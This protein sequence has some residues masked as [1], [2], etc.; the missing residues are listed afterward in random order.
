MHFSEL[1]ISFKKACLLFA[2][3]QLAQ[4]SF[5]QK[6]DSTQVASHFS[7]AVSVTHNGIS[8]IPSFSLG[9]PAAIFDMAVG[10]RRLSFE[11]QFRFALAGKPWSFLFW[12]RYKLFKNSKL[13]ISIGAHPALNFKTESFSTGGATRE[14]IIS[15]RYLAGELAPNY[16]LTKHISVGLYYLYSHGFD[17]GARNTHFLTC[18]TSFSNLQI[19]KQFFLKVTPQIYYLKMDKQDGFYCS[20]TLTLSRKNFPFSISSIINKTIK[21]NILASKDFIWNATLVYAFS[22]NYVQQ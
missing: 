16:L 17:Q 19:A 9:K 8:L 1:Q 2:L 5:A 4:C 6:T 18:N 22:G 20:S 21:T 12:W 11:P 3:W 15:R 14:I 7:G 13:S 10:K